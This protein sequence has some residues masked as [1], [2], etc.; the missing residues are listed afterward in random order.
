[1]SFAGLSSKLRRQDNVSVVL[2]VE[3]EAKGKEL[4]NGVTSN[5]QAS[6]NTCSLVG[7]VVVNTERL[8][9][10]AT[11]IA[12][13]SARSRTKKGDARVGRLLEE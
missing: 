4:R 5:P 7:I 9:Q 1:M 6:P 13:E 8:I 2:S 3:R 11:P 12:Q 10:I